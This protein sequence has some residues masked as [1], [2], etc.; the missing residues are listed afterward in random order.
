MR[1]LHL[2]V[3]VAAAAAIAACDNAGEERVLSISATGVVN[4]F[5]YLDA[6]GNRQLNGGEPGLAG[7]RVGLIARGTADTPFTAQTGVQGNV[8]FAGVP[9]GH[10]TVT[11]DTGTFGDSIGVTR[12]DSAGIQV[13]PGDSAAFLVTVSYPAVTVAGARALPL[14]EKVFVEGLVLVTGGV[15]G[16]S[17]I[18]LRDTTGSIRF[19]GATFALAQAGDTARFLGVRAARSGQPVLSN[20]ALVGLFG[21]GSP[22]P[23]SDTVSNAVALTAGGGPAF[24]LDAAFVEV[25]NDTIVDTL[26]LTAAPDAGDFRMRVFDGTDTLV[27]VLDQPGG[28]WTT[29]TAY[30]PG[31]VITQLRGLLVPTGSGTW[32]L[33]PRSPTDLRCGAAAC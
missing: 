16:D 17:T 19:T 12:I 14:G 7:V 18:H 23:P 20:V 10:Y 6:N 33:K 3:R 26:T 9:V 2:C 15:F 8:R 29:F 22:T 1:P 24:A 31:R 28:S 21:V 4:A 27:V 32:R 13:P 30:A 11:V 5:V 25:P